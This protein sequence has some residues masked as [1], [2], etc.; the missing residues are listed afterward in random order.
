MA[1]IGNL[2]SWFQP[3]PEDIKAPKPRKPIASAPPPP[4]APSQSLAAIEVATTPKA[5]GKV[6]APRLSSAK[7]TRQKAKVVKQAEAM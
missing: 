3:H 4:Q 7:G 6:L 2:W 5:T 1:I